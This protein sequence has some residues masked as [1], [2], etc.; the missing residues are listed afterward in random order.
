MVRANIG[1]Q[2]Y[3]VGPSDAVLYAPGE[4][5]EDVQVLHNTYPMLLP[6]EAGE[7]A[8]ELEEVVALPSSEQPMETLMRYTLNPSLTESKLVADKLVMRGMAQLDLLYM[9]TDGN[10][11]S[12]GSEIPFSQ[13]AQLEQQYEPDAQAEI[14]FGITALEMEL[15]EDGTKTLKAGITAQYIIYDKKEIS[16]VEDLYSPERNI[17]LTTAE[18][19]LPSVLDVQNQ[20]FRAE[21]T[22][23]S[24]TGRI[25][26]ATFIPHAPLVRV[27][28]D[29]VHA[30]VSGT[31]QLLGIDGE[32]N[33]QSENSRWEDDWTI[34]AS[35]DANI[36]IGL[37]SQQPP[38]SSGSAVRTE[39]QAKA[40]TTGQRPMQTVT[41]AELSEAVEPDPNR[42]SLIL[43][44]AGEETL[45]EI[46]KKTGST[47]EAILR[48]NGLQQEPAP[49]QMLLIPVL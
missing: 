9:G 33:L 47:V 19:Q 12:W 26:D 37:Q 38:Q 28:E 22:P 1:I 10:L 42:P 35:D 39:L 17:K 31:F 34:L 23:Q 24:I 29:R 44:K 6:V 20:V 46:A 13:Y 21:M 14:C 11:H 36:H 43:R 18:L 8:F 40:M 25:L 16:V 27:E 49:E 48:L 2:A 4:L 7:K 45:W 30:Q 3:A 32:G 5:P 15:G 41:G